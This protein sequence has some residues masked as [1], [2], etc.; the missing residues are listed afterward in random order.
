[1]TIARHDLGTL[2][3]A[4][5]LAGPMVSAGPALAAEAAP[6]LT[7]AAVRQ[8]CTGDCR[9][10]VGATLP[11]AGDELPKNWKERLL[12]LDS[13]GDRAITLDEVQRG[14]RRR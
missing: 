8:G 13:N 1:M 2:L 10:V 3:L 11:L 4:A 5:A 9:L 14:L 12:R 7:L 6:V